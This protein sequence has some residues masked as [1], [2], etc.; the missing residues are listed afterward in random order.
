MLTIKGYNSNMTKQGSKQVTELCKQI[1]T[2]LDDNKAEDIAVIDLKGKSSVAD[3]M[4]IAT[5]QSNRQVAGLAGKVLDFIK[6]LIDTPMRAE[7]MREG[8]WV[9][10][11]CGDIIVHIFRPEV[12]EF[13][14][15]EK[16][17][18]VTEKSEAEKIMMPAE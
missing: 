5:G 10:M 17:W 13:Y 7:G 1:E 3:Y 8:D 16:I 4:I 15:I 12:R 18:E 9:L 14:N 11:D 6:P 2:L